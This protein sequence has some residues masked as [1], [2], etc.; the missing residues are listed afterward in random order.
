MEC[1]DL[2]KFGNKLKSTLSTLR[3][4]RQLHKITPPPH[5]KH[6]DLHL[7]LYILCFLYNSR[8]INIRRDIKMDE[9]MYQKDKEVTENTL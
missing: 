6:N 1:D 9:T 4:D 5:L 2:N 3:C 8:G 7:Q